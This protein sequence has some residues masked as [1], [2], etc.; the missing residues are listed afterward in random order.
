MMEVLL[1]TSMTEPQLSCPEILMTPPFAI[2]A[3]RALQEETVTP[4]PDPPPVVPA[5]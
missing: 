3:V 5:P 1:S 2:A 4:A